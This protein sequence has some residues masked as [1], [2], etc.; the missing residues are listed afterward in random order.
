M[1]ENDLNGETNKLIRDL[2]AQIKH[3]KHKDKTS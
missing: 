3:I 2:S 1:S